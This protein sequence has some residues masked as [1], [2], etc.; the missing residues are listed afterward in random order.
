MDYT[1]AMNPLWIVSALLIVVALGVGS[2]AIGAAAS[3]N[4]QPR[5]QFPIGYAGRGLILLAIMAASLYLSVWVH[6]P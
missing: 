3:S 1:S 5:D 4:Q 6:L 2:L